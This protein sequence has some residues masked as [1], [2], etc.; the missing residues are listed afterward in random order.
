VIGIV[1]A[2]RMVCSV[3]ICASRGASPPICRGQHIGAR[4]RRHRR[5]CRHDREIGAGKAEPQRQNLSK[6]GQGHAI[7]L[8]VPLQTT[9]ISRAASRQL[10][11]SCRSGLCPPAIP[12]DTVWKRC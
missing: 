12:C 1:M 5:A 3:M 10:H 6:A 7:G 4:R 8:Y 11:E 2:A 9:R